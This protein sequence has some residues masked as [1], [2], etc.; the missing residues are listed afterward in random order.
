M[1]QEMVT[2]MFQAKSKTYEKQI[3]HPKRKQILTAKNN[4]TK[5]Q[6]CTIPKKQI[7]RTKDMKIQTYLWM[8][9]NVRCYIMQLRK[10]M[11]RGAWK[12]LPC[13]I[14]LLMTKLILAT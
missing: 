3:T 8:Y 5:I 7:L 13:T 6:P 12:Y 10:A 1:K 9:I 11:R 2:L 4:R 14:M